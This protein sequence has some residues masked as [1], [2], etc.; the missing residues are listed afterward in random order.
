[1]NKKG[2]RLI[3]IY[4]EGALH[5]L[6]GYESF[7]ACGLDNSDTVTVFPKAYDNL[8]E[9]SSVDAAMVERIKA[10]REKGRKN[11]NHVE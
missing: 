9:G 5:P 3:A 7:I 2:T 10:A 11:K 6:V 4:F 8:L 1:V